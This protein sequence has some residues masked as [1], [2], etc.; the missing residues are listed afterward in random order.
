M[1]ELDSPKTP[2]RPARHTLSRVVAACGMALASLAVAAP[3][4]AGPLSG[5]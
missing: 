1:V 2:R 5:C 4:W 3:S